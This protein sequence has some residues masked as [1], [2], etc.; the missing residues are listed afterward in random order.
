MINFLLLV[1]LTLTTFSGCT[2]KHSIEQNDNLLIFS[3]Q[4]PEANRVQFSSSADNYILH[5][6][7]KNKSGIWQI[8]V[9]F[10]LDIKYFYMVDGSMYL[11]ECRFKE[12][13][14]FGAENCLFLP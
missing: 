1:L 8:T 9:P 10:G 14:D 7:I 11:P 4:F 13:D 12:T 2:A 5:D 3:L 6:I